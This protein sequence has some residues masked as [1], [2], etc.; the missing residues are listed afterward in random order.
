MN[1]PRVRVHIYIPVWGAAVSVQTRFHLSGEA[2]VYV[3]LFGI[4]VLRIRMFPVLS[5]S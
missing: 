5:T 3:F 4:A 1:V 2:P